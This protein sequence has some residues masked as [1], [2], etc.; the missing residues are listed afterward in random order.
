MIARKRSG[1]GWL[2][3]EDEKV[4]CGIDEEELKASYGHD[5]HRDARLARLPWLGTWQMY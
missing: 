4:H 1:L 3:G 5:R 2:L